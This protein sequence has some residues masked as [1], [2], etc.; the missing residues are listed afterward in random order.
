MAKTTERRPRNAA[1]LPE[2]DEPASP[3]PEPAGDSVTVSRLGV[4]M[5]PEGRIAWDSTTEKTRV[6][7]R[8]M[9]ADP[10]LPAQLGV[11]RPAAAAAATK[12]DTFPPEMCGVVYDALGVLLKG[13]AQRAGYSAEQSA[14]LAFTPEEKATLAQPTAAV[15]NKYGGALTK[16]QEELTLA[17]VMGSIISGKLAI[18]RAQPAAMAAAAIQ[19]A[20]TMIG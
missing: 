5:T 14:T 12:P 6:K 7:L 20:G 4:N 1:A 18:L 3:A 16:Y 17:F 11:D 2:P 15:L 9:L 19:P 10:E 8:A 13:L